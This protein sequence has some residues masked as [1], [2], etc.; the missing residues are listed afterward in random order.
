MGRRMNPDEILHI[1]AYGCS[2]CDVEFLRK[3]LL[4]MS[5]VADYHP[6]MT[7]CPYVF[8]KE[9]FP[10]VTQMAQHVLIDHGVILSSL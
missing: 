7:T 4:F 1:E 2:I 3:P 9:E 10:T 6:E 8:C 5:H